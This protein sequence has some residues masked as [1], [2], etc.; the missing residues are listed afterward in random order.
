MSGHNCNV[1]LFPS[2]KKGINFYVSGAKTSV[3]A[4]Y[5]NVVSTDNCVVLG[6]NEGGKVILVEH[7]MAACA[8][9]EI[10]SLDVC[11]DSPELPILDGSAF[12]W[13]N[14]L[15]D[16][17][18]NQEN[19]SGEFSFEKPLEFSDG[20]INITLIPA[21]QFKITYCVN[22]DHPDFKNRRVS[23][24]LNKNKKEILTARTFG[25]LKDLE[26]FQNASMSLGVTSENTVG[27][28]QTGYTT[29][30]HSEF[31][32]ANH[33]ILDLIGDLYLIGFNP[34]KFKAH[35]IAKNAGHKTH[36]E[37]AKVID[38]YLK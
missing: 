17:G 20:D 11:I 30:L 19:S 4:H 9:A 14:L 26:K 15:K 25:Y 32:P 37:F 22:L 2:E 36:I 3:A 12:K 34:L 10:D 13:H 33:K 16:A 35:I 21:D 18:I 31:E 28:T 1:K 38:Y 5:K 24:D 27:L 29:E 6:N 23:L 8:F 7:F